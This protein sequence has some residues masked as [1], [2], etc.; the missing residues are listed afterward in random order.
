MAAE[1]R[2][3]RALGGGRFRI[4]SGPYHRRF[5]DGYY[6]MHVSLRV[7]LAG[8]GLRLEQVTPAATE[9]FEV[10]A[11]ADEIAI[12][13]WFEGRLV[14]GLEFSEAAGRSDQLE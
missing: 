7:R 8:S 12:D 1:V 2:Q 3:L 6:P 13:A 9:G 11:P 10:S 14:I 4:E 5:L